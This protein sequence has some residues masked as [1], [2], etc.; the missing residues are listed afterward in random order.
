MP[1]NPRIFLY[2]WS[3]FGEEKPQKSILIH[4][5]FGLF[6]TLLLFIIYFCILRYSWLLF[7]LLYQGNN[8]IPERV[9]ISGYESLGLQSQVFLVIVGWCVLFVLGLFHVTWKHRLKS[10]FANSYQEHPV[11]SLTPSRAFPF[12]AAPFNFFPSNI[13]HQLSRKL[14][15]IFSFFSIFFYSGLTIQNQHT[16]T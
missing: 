10:N 6:R 9:W 4:S 3:F 1:G 11:F 16:R 7:F 12:L 2:L 8:C 13:L 14:L 15:G 5:K